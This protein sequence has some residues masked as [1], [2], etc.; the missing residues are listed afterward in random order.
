MMTKKIMKKTIFIIIS[1]AVL[2]IILVGLITLNFRSNEI[3]YAKSNEL[4]KFEDNDGK[5]TAPLIYEYEGNYQNCVNEAP[6]IY[7]RLDKSDYTYFT[8]IGKVKVERDNNIIHSSTYAFSLGSNRTEDDK[9]EI[10]TWGDKDE[11]LTTGHLKVN[12]KSGNYKITITEVELRTGIFSTLKKSWDA[13]YSI[14]FTI[15]RTSPEIKF[16]GLNN[17]YLHFDISNTYLYIV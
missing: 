11:M 9:E 12:N 6:K 2:L 1:F 3:A 15:D 10:I 16:L 8:F 17:T 5:F 13:T 14:S 4:F 7:F